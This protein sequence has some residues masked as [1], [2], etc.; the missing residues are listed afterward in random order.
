MPE[1]TPAPEAV[2]IG[3]RLIKKH[4]DHLEGVRIEY[5]FRDKAS[6]SNGKTVGGKARKISGLNAYLADHEESLS[7]ED[8]FVVELA[9]D[10]WSAL[11]KDQRVALVDHELLHC[12]IEV[13][14]NTGDTK[15]V[16]LSHDAE[17]FFSEIERHG[18]WHTDLDHLLKTV[19]ERK[20][21]DN[22]QLTL[23]DAAAEAAK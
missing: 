1:Y 12:S 15:L 17:V 2:R 13:D 11:S 6:K 5:V 22:A 18:F 19:E 8:F 9:K 21:E 4:H 3:D 7:P 16:L 14:E 20:L 23:D 10:V